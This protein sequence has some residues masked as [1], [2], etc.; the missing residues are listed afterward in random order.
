MRKP[1]VL[2]VEP[3]LVFCASPDHILGI[4]QQI[5]GFNKSWERPEKM[6]GKD[7]ITVVAWWNW[8]SDVTT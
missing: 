4:A 7:V 3:Q 1:I 6:V 2:I 5:L 8:L